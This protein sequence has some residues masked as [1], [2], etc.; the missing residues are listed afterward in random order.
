MIQE[1]FSN[2][3]DKFIT[4]ILPIILAAI[5]FVSAIAAWKSAS[6]AK[7]SAEAALEANALAKAERKRLIITECFK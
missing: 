7:K 1:S 2:L 5:A 4:I 3:M 6:L